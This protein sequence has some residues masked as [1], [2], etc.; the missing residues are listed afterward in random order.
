MDGP[1][2][3]KVSNYPKTG[4]YFLQ[5][6]ESGLAPNQL[7]Q[8]LFSHPLS[9]AFG[10]TQ[11]PFKNL[12]MPV[13][14]SLEQ[15]RKQ[16]PTTKEEL[17]RDQKLTSDGELKLINK[18]IIESQSGI[19]G[20][21]IKKAMKAIFTG[22]GLVGMSLP[23]KIFEARSTLQRIS[24][25]MCYIT[26]YL[27]RA[28][29]TTDPLERA[30]LCLTCLI[31]GISMSGSQKKPFN[32]YLGETLESEFSDGSKMYMEHTSHHPPVSNFYID[33]SYGAKVSGRFEQVADMSMNSMD[34]IYRGPLNIEFADGHKITM[35][36]PWAHTSGVVFGSRCF[37]FDKRG[38][39]VDTRNNIKG[40]FEMG[41]I[42]K[43]G[44]HKSKRCDTFSGEIYTYDPSKHKAYGENFKNVQD[45]FKAKDK[46]KQLCTIDGSVFDAV[47][48]SGAQY[49]DFDSHRVERALPIEHPLP[50]DFRFREDIA[51]LEHGNKEQAQEW[52]LKLEEIQRWDRGLR[53]EAEKKRKKGK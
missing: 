46:V 44:R 52:K 21:V 5:P 3:I 19:L 7:A 51:W 27:K 37:R 40:Y 12:L 35:F 39:Y 14:M 34:I 26:T 33:C 1:L 13:F 8:L 47:D 43:G 10:Y 17:F 28:N 48:F 24:D 30:K 45:S 20:D 25:N 50:S 23:I 4:S 9:F 53:Q 31:S 15:L 11:K 29:Q 36:Y 22:Q 49:W 32:P 41:E 38:C 6:L 2:T 18:E 16:P 42:L